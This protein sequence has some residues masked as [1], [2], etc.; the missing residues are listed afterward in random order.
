LTHTTKIVLVVGD[1]FATRIVVTKALREAGFQVI[2]AASADEAVIILTARAAVDLILTDFRMPGS[3]N[4][5][6]L[7]RLV[8]RTRPKVKV[9]FLS[10][11]A[12]DCSLR[13]WGHGFLSKPCDTASIVKTVTNV[14]A[15]A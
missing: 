9:V 13:A 7:A 1:E 4:G 5:L 8:R 6:G 3:M 11:D 12:G 10:A 2:A 14:L 15:A